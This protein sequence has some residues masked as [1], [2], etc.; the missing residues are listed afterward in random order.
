[1]TKEHYIKINGYSN[2][3]W[4]WGAEDDDFYFRIEENKLKLFRPSQEFGRYKMNQ[5]SH[6]RSDSWNQINGKKLKNRERRTNSDG[7][8]SIYTLSYQ[9]E[10]KIQLLYTLIS[11]YLSPS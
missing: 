9:V 6:Y 4:G 10:H 11:I 7:L 2:N 8:N 3:F 1:M 5:N